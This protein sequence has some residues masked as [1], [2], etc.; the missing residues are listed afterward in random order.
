MESIDFESRRKIGEGEKGD[1][2]KRSVSSR[3][4]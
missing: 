4:E 2:E 1:G 3:C